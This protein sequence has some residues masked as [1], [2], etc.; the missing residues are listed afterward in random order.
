MKAECGK[1]WITSEVYISNLGAMILG[2]TLKFV[3]NCDCLPGEKA[4]KKAAVPVEHVK[5]RDK[6][7]KRID[8]Y[9]DYLRTP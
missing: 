8:L 2:P 3:S 5:G 9:R 4:R 1:G 7:A 6:V